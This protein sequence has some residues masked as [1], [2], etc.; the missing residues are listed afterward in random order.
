MIQNAIAGIL[1]ILLLQGCGYKSTVYGTWKN[2]HINFDK[3]A[4][5]EFLNHKLI[6]CIKYN[7]VVGVKSIMSDTLKKIAGSN[8]DSLVTGVSSAFLTDQYTVLDEYNVHNLATG[9]SNSLHANT[10]SD[11]D[12]TID[13]V[14]FNRE[15]YVSL[16]LVSDLTGDILVTAIYGNYDGKWEINVLQVGRYRI[17]N[18]TAIDY[19]KAAK[20]YYGKSCFIDAADN[21]FIANRFLKPAHEFFHFKKEKEVEEFYNK[22][23]SETSVKYPLPLALENIP[24]KPKIFNIYPQLFEG[25]YFPMIRYL[26]SIRIDDSIQLTRENEKVQIEVKKIFTGIGGNKKITMYEAFNKMPD[27]KHAENFRWFI[28]RNVVSPGTFLKSE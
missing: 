15:M 27:D 11:N 25:E 4:E 1:L 6:N 5:L 8:I 16:L 2:D 23:V 3:R 9:V 12:Y 14:A 26:S 22:V 20:G 18:K 7:D 19:Y 28:D 21:L 17:F 24:G 13:Y 10:G